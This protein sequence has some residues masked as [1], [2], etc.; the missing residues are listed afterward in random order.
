MGLEGA[1]IG[2]VLLCCFVVAMHM[3]QSMLQPEVFND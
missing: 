1:I 3:Y 2:P